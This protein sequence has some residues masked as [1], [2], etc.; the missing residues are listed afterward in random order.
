MRIYVWSRFLAWTGRQAVPEEEVQEVLAYL[1]SLPMQVFTLDILVR[2]RK[3][4]RELQLDGGARH[5]QTQSPGVYIRR[6]TNIA[7]D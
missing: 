7:L 6:E 4:E 2:P 3:L 1:K 5:W